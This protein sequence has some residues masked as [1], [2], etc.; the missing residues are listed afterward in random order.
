MEL[1]SFEKQ[2]VLGCMIPHLGLP[3]AEWA[4]WQP[5]NGQPWDIQIHGDVYIS[6]FDKP[7]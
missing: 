4:S 5:W 3:L 7:S 1:Q 2:K 6:I